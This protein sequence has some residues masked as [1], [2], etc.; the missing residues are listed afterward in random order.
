MRH[1]DLCCSRVRRTVA[2]P[3]QDYCPVI[4][5]PSQTY[6]L[7]HDG[8]W[9]GNIRVQGK[10]PPNLWG[11]KEAMEGFH[12][13]SNTSGRCCAISG[14][15]TYAPENSKLAWS[16]PGLTVSHIIPPQ[17][18]DVFPVDRSDLDGE[19]DELAEKW[20]MTWDPRE[21]GIVLLGHFH[22][23]WKARLVAIEP[24]TLTVRCFGPYDSIA[25]Y[26]GRVA[27]FSNV[28]NKEILRW[29]YRMCVY[30]N[31]TAKQPSQSPAAKQGAGIT[32]PK[33]PALST[34]ST[35][36]RPAPFTASK[37]LPFALCPPGAREAPTQAARP[38]KRP[39]TDQDGAALPQS[40]NS[41]T[42]SGDLAKQLCTLKCII[43]LGDPDGSDPSCPNFSKHR[44]LGFGVADTAV[45]KLNMTT[46]SS[47]GLLR[48]EDVPKSQ[49]GREII[50]SEYE[51]VSREPIPILKVVLPYGY[52]VV[53]KGV[54][55]PD[56]S[57]STAR[58]GAKVPTFTPLIE[59]DILVKIGPQLAG[60]RV[61][62]C[63]GLLKF[64]KELRDASS[65]GSIE[66]V[67]L[68]S[69]AEVPL[70]KAT[71]PRHVIQEEIRRTVED[72]RSRGVTFREPLVDA[73]LRWNQEAQQVMVVNF[74]GAKME[75]SNDVTVFR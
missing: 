51:V 29:H 66:S 3:P 27:H 43:R 40:A 28:P 38:R 56:H 14:L 42:S 60:E 33:R 75:T 16:D 47:C 10:I 53:G 32:A 9:Q 23:M 13:L 1:S 26:E 25:A 54:V 57:I 48:D 46:L 70:S 34:S 24:S 62:F 15:G 55:R 65:N 30:E 74:A 7:S 22:A 31:I 41:A 73:D 71:V 67:L 20:R 52:T 72:I 36:T 59:A 39:R 63:L 2:K 37:T 45:H 50:I 58:E 6:E 19:D 64:G 21:N 8:S 4:T 61:P 17:H 44:R 11:A 18:F 69:S 12:S 68:L 5:Q 35:G 49:L